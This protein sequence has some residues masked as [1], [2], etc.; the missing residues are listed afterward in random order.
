MP[1]S[2]WEERFS[3]QPQSLHDVPH[4]VLSFIRMLIILRV[5]KTKHEVIDEITVVTAKAQLG[6]SQQK[7]LPSPALV[8]HHDH[9]Y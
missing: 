3:Q 1:Y 8:Y 2:Y 9:S 4:Q 6:L 5:G 7:L